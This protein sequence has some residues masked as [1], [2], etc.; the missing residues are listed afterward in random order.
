M[1]ELLLFKNHILFVTNNYS[2]MNAS[3]VISKKVRHSGK[4]PVFLY[5]DLISIGVILIMIIF[6]VSVLQVAGF[7]INLFT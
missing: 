6:K 1:L 5:A 7:V 3:N 4:E 2:V